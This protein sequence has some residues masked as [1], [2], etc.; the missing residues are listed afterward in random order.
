[1]KKIFYL[2]LI[3][4]ACMISVASN[5]YKITTT[6]ITGSIHNSDFSTLDG[7]YSFYTPSLSEVSIV[8]CLNEVG[9]LL[10]SDYCNTTTSAIA[11]I[12][13]YSSMGSYYPINLLDSNTTEIVHDALMFKIQ[14]MA[15]TPACWS[16]SSSYLSG[17]FY[18]FL[19]GGLSCTTIANPPFA[20]DTRIYELGGFN[21]STSQ[22]IYCLATSWTDM[23]LT[24]I[25]PEEGDWW[26]IRNIYLGYEG[27]PNQ[28]YKS[29]IIINKIELYAI[30]VDES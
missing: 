7:W 28:P 11:G 2:V 13:N 1:M 6:N 29:G 8:N 14:Y 3:I 17:N 23:Y 26:Q 20:V 30:R 19:Q 4:S 5:A 10:K 24:F 18:V 25:P 16:E 12:Q 22:P 15:S 27:M 21:V 9:V